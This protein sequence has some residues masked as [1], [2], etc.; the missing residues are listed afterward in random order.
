M[1]KIGFQPTVYTFSTLMNGFCME[2][3]VDQAIKLFGEINETD[4]KI[5]EEKGLDPNVI[6]YSTLIDSLCKKRLLKKGLTVF[7]QML[8]KGIKPNVYTYNI[9]LDAFYKRG[10]IC[11]VEVVIAMMK[12]ERVKFNVVTRGKI[13]KS[14][15]IIEIGKVTYI[16]VYTTIIIEFHIIGIL[17][18]LKMLEE[19]GPNPNG[20]KEK[21]KAISLA[22]SILEGMF[23]ESPAGAGERID[24]ANVYARAILRG[25]KNV[26]AGDG[27]DIRER[28]ISV[29][30]QLIACVAAN[31]F[32]YYAFMHPTKQTFI[33]C[34]PGISNKNH[35][36]R[37][38]DAPPNV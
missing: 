18:E 24:F 4:F 31:S 17:M 6:T 10:M 1:M 11:R 9:L 15:E 19:R 23:Y 16:N 14:R 38:V 36:F 5:L 33:I 3:R 2:R 35:H 22:K 37:Q 21:G 20:N 34:V 7:S 26:G 25:L 12:K 27:H 29:G 30:E 8:E 13:S 32:Q 28:I